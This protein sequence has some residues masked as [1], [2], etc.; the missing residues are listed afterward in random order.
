[1]TIARWI[2]DPGEVLADS[3]AHGDELIGLEDEMGDVNVGMSS[4]EDGLSA[5]VVNGTVVVIE[6]VLICG[7]ESIA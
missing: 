7:W 5:G 1:M 2:G 3:G 4:G 6:V